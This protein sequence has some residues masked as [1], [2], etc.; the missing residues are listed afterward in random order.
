MAQI[1]QQPLQSWQHAGENLEAEIFFIAQPVSSSLEN[2]DFIVEA[3]DE[4]E[5]DL[6][7]TAPTASTT[8][9]AASKRASVRLLGIPLWRPPVLCP[10][11]PHRA[12]TGA[13]PLVF[14][15]SRTHAALP[16]ASSGGDTV[17]PHPVTGN[18]SRRAYSHR[19]FE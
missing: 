16:E 8:S 1:S 3:F 13:S 12:R 15:R 19:S 6:G 10:W 9:A 7:M 5:R 18:G 17:R 4:A 11:C 2:A 14:P